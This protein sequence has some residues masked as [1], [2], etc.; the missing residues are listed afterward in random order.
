MNIFYDSYEIQVRTLCC[1]S[2][3][4]LISSGLSKRS[5]VSGD[6]CTKTIAQKM[7][8]STKDFFSKFD[9]IRRNLRIWSHLLKKSFVEKF[10]FCAVNFIFI[11]KT[12][13]RIFWFICLHARYGNYISNHKAIIY[14]YWSF[15]SFFRNK[16]WS[17]TFIKPQIKNCKVLIKNICLPGLIK[18]TTTQSKC[19]VV[20]NSTMTLISKVYTR[21]ASVK[22]I[23]LQ[24][25]FYSCIS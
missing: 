17:V 11:D 10:I 15:E 3:L 18:S 14:R 7:N 22:A 24:S 20:P 6:L 9:Q 19:C 5:G 16:D 13:R 2:F 8:F 12:Y 23:I 4:T 1:R 25:C 21:G